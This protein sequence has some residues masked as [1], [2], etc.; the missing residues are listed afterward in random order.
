MTSPTV[1]ATSPNSPTC[2]S[3]AT[4]PRRQEPFAPKAASTSVRHEG[5]RTYEHVAGSCRQPPRVLVSD[6]SGQSNMVY[7]LRQHGLANSLNEEGRRELLKRVKDMEHAGYDLETADGTFD[8]RLSSLRPE[9]FLDIQCYRSHYPVRSC[10]RNCEFR[11]N[12][13][14]YQPLRRPRP[15]TCSRCR[16][17]ES[18]FPNY[19]PHRTGPPD[20]LQ[21]RVSIQ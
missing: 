17:C 10:H 14:R 3:A 1:A 19:I 13:G 2:P 6:L 4:S 11:T 8:S 5:F 21:V 12:D 9:S 18:V 7:R 15:R 20:R 16:N